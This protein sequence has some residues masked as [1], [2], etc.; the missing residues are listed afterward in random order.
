MT[1]PHPTPQ[2]LVRGVSAGYT[3]TT[4]LNQLD[5]D[6]PPLTVTAVMGPNGS[7]K[8]TLL[9]LLAGVIPATSGT[10]VHRTAVR[11]AFVMQRSAAADTLPLTVRETVTMGRWGRLGPF[12]RPSPKDR[13]AVESSMERLDVA[14]LAERQL[15]ELSGGQRQRVLVAQGLAQGADLLL[16]D[17]PAGAVDGSARETIARVLDDVAAEGVA[18]VQA[19]HDITAARRAGYCLLLDGGHVRAAG[20]PREVLDEA[21]RK[22][23]AEPFA[24]P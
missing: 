13:R 10:V 24:R 16:L 20:P 6:I 4:V 7:G 12:R 1:A 11:P 5:V 23:P 19:T 9:G 2:V 14:D 3:R 17:E 21:E 8:S 22:R 15:G 18:V